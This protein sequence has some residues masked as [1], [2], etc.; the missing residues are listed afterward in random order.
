MEKK[1]E[2]GEEI[3]NGLKIPFVSCKT[4]KKKVY[5]KDGENENI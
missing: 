5:I 3:F 1:K 2:D 4:I